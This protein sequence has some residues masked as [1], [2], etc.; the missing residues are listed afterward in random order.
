MTKDGEITKPMAPV[1]SACSSVTSGAW[2]SGAKPKTTSWDEYEANALAM[3]EDLMKQDNYMPADGQNPEGFTAETNKEAC[4]EEVARLYLMMLNKKEGESHKEVYDRIN[5]D[6]TDLDHIKAAFMI[7][8]DKSV[9][10][11]AQPFLKL[12][13]DST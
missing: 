10:D 6:G 3:D 8:N 4:K 13:R 2:K 9:P 12:S 5:D 1:K 7:D 11:D